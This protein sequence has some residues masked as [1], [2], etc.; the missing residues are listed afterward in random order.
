MAI[1]AL[2][3]IPTAVIQFCQDAGYGE[4]ESFESLK[5]GAVNLTRRLA[6]SS[7]AKLILKQSPNPPADLYPCEAL[8]LR[9]LKAAG[10][11]TP[12]VLAVDADFLLL[13]DLGST[14][15]TD[16]SWEALGRA[17]GQLHLHTNAQF[18]FEQDNYLGLLR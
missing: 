17:I 5:G 13:D 1:E 11:R 12:N 3:P 14:P 16:L 10:L 15:M 2:Q 6:T 18:G 9:T 4:I 8:S 7:G